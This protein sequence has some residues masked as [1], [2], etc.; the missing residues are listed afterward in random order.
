MLVL[1][2]S[3]LSA[4]PVVE[5]TSLHYFSIAVDDRDGDLHLSGAPEPYLQLAY[6]ERERLG[7]SREIY[8][9]LDGPIR[10]LLTVIEAVRAGAVEDGELAT[11]ELTFAA[12]KTDGTIV[13]RHRR[14][15]TFELG[16]LPGDFFCVPKK[17]IA[18]PFNT[19]A[20]ERESRYRA[21]LENLALGDPIEL[22]RPRG[23][24]YLVTMTLGVSKIAGGGQ[25]IAGLEGASRGSWEMLANIY[26]YGVREVLGSTHVSEEGVQ[27]RSGQLAAYSASLQRLADLLTD[28]EADR[29]TLAALT[30]RFPVEVA[31]LEMLVALDI[32]EG[33]PEDALRRMYSF[34]SRFA[35]EPRLAALHA[36]ATQRAETKRSLMI[37]RMD[38][39]EELSRSPVEIVSPQPDDLI[40]GRAEVVFDPGK[41]DREILR[42]ELFAA[43]KPVASIDGPPYRLDFQPNE[44]HRRV[45]LE[46][47][48]YFADETKATNRLRVRS[49][50][51]GAE[52]EIHLV[53][54]RAVAARGSNRFLT[55]LSATDFQL[56]EADRAKEVA[57][58]GRNTAPLSIALLIDTSRSMSRGRLLQAQTAVWALLRELGGGDEAAVFQFDHKVMMLSDFR[59]DYREMEGL[60]HTLHP[61]LGT[62]L[63]D[64]I[65]AA[66]AALRGRAGNK[67][68][69]IVSDGQDT[70]S[71]TDGKAVHDIVA[72]TDTMVYSVFL[73]DHDA[74]EEKGYAY[75]SRLSEATGSITTRLENIDRLDRELSRIYRELKSFYLIDF[76]SSISPFDPD[77]LEIRVP[78]SG[79]RVR[80]HQLKEQ[81]R[82]P[83][84]R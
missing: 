46:L 39:F 21:F 38:G 58:I 28:G 5:R 43:G 23:P 40:G 51:L 24:G 75:L 47:K 14:R 82:Q 83:E 60:I 71:E 61:R 54:L 7:L 9:M 48:T 37:A 25:A 2:I 63:Y 8:A 31:P 36:E 69:I 6:L 53:R 67:V 49:V 10:A 16:S 22:D 73:G 13:D 30:R 3:L 41:Q 70:T 33:R 15:V 84:F 72:A 56:R 66:E 1:L 52:E 29:E 35:K 64:A 78:R 11:L 79:T 81:P 4:E 65:A 20:L 59:T 68:I 45:D 74:L 55:N 50:Y 12:R 32:A 76:Y 26:R 17:G 18:A 19:K 42:A 77:Q 44:R 34:E 57:F 80:F 62:S 27:T